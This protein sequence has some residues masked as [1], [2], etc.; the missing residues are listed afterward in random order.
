[1]PDLVIYADGNNA[2][3]RHEVPVFVP[4]PFLY[5]ERDGRKIAVV[6][7]FETARLEPLGITAMPM[8]AFGLDELIASGLPA[9]E[10]A[11]ALLLRACE[12]LEVTEAVVPATFPLELADRLRA[13]GVEL[14]TRKE[15][16]ADRRRVK[17]AAEIEGIRRAQ[18]AAEA[19][20]A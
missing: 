2:E 12:S 14:A 1:M 13:K 20:M 18:A 15:L 10:R 6:P 11:L 4:D 8:E 16:F 17:N 5:L 7:G 19:A 3:M 9:A